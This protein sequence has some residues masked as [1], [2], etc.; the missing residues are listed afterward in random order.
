MHDHDDDPAATTPS[1]GPP[2]AQSFVAA[3]EERRLPS[4]RLFPKADRHC[5]ASLSAPFHHL[6]QWVGRPLEKPPQRM[7]SFDEMRRYLH[8]ALWPFVRNRPGAEA[9][10]SFAVEDA[11]EDGVVIMELSF[12]V[13]LAACYETGVDGYLEFIAGLV[14]RHERRIALRPEIGVSKNR[15]PATQVPL[16]LAC[17]AS[18]VFRSIDL[19][20]NEDARP[21]EDYRRMYRAARRR[22]LKCKAHAGEFGDAALV[23]R[24]I[25]ALDLDEVQ[26]GVAA[27]SSVSTM[28]LL[29]ERR[30][31]L[32]VCP[33][34]N[35]ALS[36]APDLARH[37]LRRLLDGGVRVSINTDDMTIFGR[38]L[39]QEYLALA[40]SGPCSA[41]EL[42]TIRLDSLLD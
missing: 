30:I 35:V 28:R 18:G 10:A 12:D 16:A 26:H 22:G 25:R 36:V 14:R 39:S 8:A 9:A 13:D 31:R 3:L 20:G 21:P 41:R 11:I 34:S 24:T 40:E 5:H 32:N 6:E 42:E 2:A 19:Y 7:A 23:E 27:A 17:I 38:T 29:R 15:S 4:L 1:S 33:G 37:P